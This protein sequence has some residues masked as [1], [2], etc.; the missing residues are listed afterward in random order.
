MVPGNLHKIHATSAAHELLVKCNI[1]VLQN[2]HGFMNLLA[3]G[4]KA[5][6]EF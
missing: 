5:A 6:V 3:E 2:M 4:L 1:L